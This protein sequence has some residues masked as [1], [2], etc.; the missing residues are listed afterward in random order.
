MSYTRSRREDT[1]AG[2]IFTALIFLIKEHCAAYA[3]QC[4]CIA[5]KA[6]TNKGV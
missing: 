5:Q 6:T 1:T 3:N 4:A 2:W